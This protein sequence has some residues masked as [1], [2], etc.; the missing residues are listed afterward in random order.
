[1]PWELRASESL[2]TATCTTFVLR[3]SLV[4]LV[5]FE[6]AVADLVVA[7]LAVLAPPTSLP[8]LVVWQ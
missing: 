8:T 7:L 4:V 5:V 2:V 6:V 1:M 3:A